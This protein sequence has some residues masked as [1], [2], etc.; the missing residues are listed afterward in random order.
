MTEL[1]FAFGPVEYQLKYPIEFWSLLLAYKLC[2][3]LGY[4]MVL[5]TKKTLY[6]RKKTKVEESIIK[7]IPAF[8]TLSIVASVLGFKGDASFIEK[9][10]PIFWFTSAFK[11]VLTPGEVYTNKMIRVLSGEAPN[12]ALNIFLF[13]ISFSKILIAPLLI[14]YW[15][16]IS[17]PSKVF[18]ILAILLPLL[19]SMSFGTNKGV[20]D[21]VILISTSLSLYFIHNKVS[22]G[23]YGFSEKRF[24]LTST[25]VLFLGAIYFFGNAMGE[26]GGSI[27]YIETQ[28]PLARIS[29]SE[30][31]IQRSQ[32]SVYYYTYAW[33]SS[34]IV[35]GYY[36]FSLIFEQPF[37]STFG[38]G[39]SVFVRRNIESLTGIDLRRRT[40]QYK[41]DKYWG[42]SSQWHSFYS[43]IAN[44]VHYVGVGII[45]LIL[46]YYL[47]AI[48]LNFIET[49]NPY[50]MA[51][52]C[53]YTILGIFIP[54]NN[55]IF[56]FMDGLSAFFWI[57]Y[58]WIKTNNKYYGK[59]DFQR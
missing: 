56:G 25:V 54:A 28:D 17:F 45:L 23:Y 5:K 42:E 13:L 35:Q 47:G 9:L 15:K 26:R 18:G 12:K 34:Y 22:K 7:K 53:V 19:S 52:L 6:L 55:Q 36:G 50:G 8:I 48:W 40:Y 59:F 44:D 30:K 21:F 31:A 43:F 3:L 39:N 58:L 2:L 4:I 49:G 46:G 32:K 27:Q 14:Y 1:I 51:L 33:L 16:K 41:V 10:N 29:V 20:F 11:G 24:I 38:F 37:E 57:S